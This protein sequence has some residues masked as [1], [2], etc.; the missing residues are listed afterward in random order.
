MAG[1]WSVATRSERDLRKAI[2]GARKNGGSGPRFRRR[3]LENLFANEAVNSFSPCF[4]LSTPF[5][6][7]F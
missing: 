3:R 2:N 1:R 4:Y 5:F 6:F 7:R